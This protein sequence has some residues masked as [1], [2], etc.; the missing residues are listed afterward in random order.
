MNAL[1]ICASSAVCVTYLLIVLGAIVRTTGS[2]L[3]CPDWPTCYGVW[4][5][6]PAVVDASGLGFTYGQV[7]LEWIHRFIAG[8][9]LGPLIVFIALL[10]WCQRADHSLKLSGVWISMLLLVQ[11]GLGGLTVLDSNSPWSVAIHLTNA[12]ILLTALLFVALRTSP[13]KVSSS[14]MRLRI[15]AT[16]ALIVAVATMATAAM[17]AKSGASLACSSW[18]L[19]NDTSIPDFGDWPI[20]IHATHRILA[21]VLGIM[22][23]LLAWR[24]RAHDQLMRTLANAASLLVVI[25]VSLGAGLIE[26]YVPIPL[27][28]VHQAL[29]VLIFGMLASL[30]WLTNGVARPVSSLNKS[31]IEHNGHASPRPA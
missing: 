26:W 18:P 11:A 12:L 31:T 3:S 14:G 29:A 9:V 6:T 23:F 8:V 7:M 21:G 28:V 27:A 1:R 15:F 25:Q 20:A 13:S 19:C 24:L 17:T 4:L 2:G 22:I 16:L 5:P 30:F 10:T